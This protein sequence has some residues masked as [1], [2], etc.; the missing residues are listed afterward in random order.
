M[1]QGAFVLGRLLSKGN[2]VWGAFVLDPSIIIIIPQCKPI[3]M[4]A[5]G[6]I[7]GIPNVNRMSSNHVK[8]TLVER[9]RNGV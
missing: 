5:L 9:A 7:L 8:V 6:Y 2:L 4:V 3:I 1:C